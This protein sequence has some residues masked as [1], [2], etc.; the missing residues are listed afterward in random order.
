MFYINS[1]RN[2]I[3]F[4]PPKRTTSTLPVS[5]KFLL[6]QYMVRASSF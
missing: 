2:V 1:K 4:V 3:D 5:I 6:E